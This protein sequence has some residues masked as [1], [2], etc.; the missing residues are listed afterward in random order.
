[1]QRLLKNIANNFSQKK[2]ILFAAFKKTFHLVLKRTTESNKILLPK[3]MQP[4]F[5]WKNPMRKKLI[6]HKFY[7]IICELNETIFNISS[8]NIN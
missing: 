5:D 1:M 4:I 6:S 8:E 7:S 3:G 2:I